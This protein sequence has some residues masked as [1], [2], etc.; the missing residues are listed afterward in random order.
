MLSVWYLRAAVTEMRGG[1][2]ETG[3]QA[4]PGTRAEVVPPPPGAEA[5]R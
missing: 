2:K 1:M 4:S 5:R 3:M